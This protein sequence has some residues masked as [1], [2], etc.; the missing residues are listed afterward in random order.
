M[1]KNIRKQNKNL[2][3]SEIKADGRSGMWGGAYTI[4]FVYSNKG[5]FVVKG[6][7]REVQKHLDELK[8]K[9]YKYFVNFTLWKSKDNYGFP[10]KEKHRDIWSFYKDNIHITHPKDNYSLE[11]RRG[12]RRRNYQGRKWNVKSNTTHVEFAFKRMPNRWI[13]EFDLL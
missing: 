1:T 3:V 8:Q 7:Y 6:Y 4:A 11:Y 12:R 9:G 10:V 5:N 13:E 2:P